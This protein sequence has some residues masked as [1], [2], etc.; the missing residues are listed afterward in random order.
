MQYAA[1]MG[2]RTGFGRLLRDSRRC[3]PYPRPV[4]RP[5]FGRGYVDPRGRRSILN[6]GRKY[7]CMASKGAGIAPD[8]PRS[9]LQRFRL[10]AHPGGSTKRGSPAP[11]RASRGTKHGRLR[12]RPN[13]RHGR[14][15]ARITPPGIVI[16]VAA[17]P[18]SKNARLW[19]RLR[20]PTCPLS[21][22]EISTIK[23]PS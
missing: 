20:R 6:A 21:G 18:V 8:E 15:A 13:R 12:S 10:R 16:R 7:G 2:L 5:L 17:L 1:G 4:P 23:T 22:S 14:I 19:R 9:P 3:R 11:A